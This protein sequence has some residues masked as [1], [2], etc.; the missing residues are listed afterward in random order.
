MSAT[1]STAFASVE[2]LEAIQTIFVEVTCYVGEGRSDLITRVQISPFHRVRTEGNV[3]VHRRLKIPQYSDTGF[4]GNLVAP[5]CFWKSLG[6]A[7]ETTRLKSEGVS[8]N[9]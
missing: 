4:E 5:I 9:G 3:Q 1:R 7:E 2:K 8:E 6:F